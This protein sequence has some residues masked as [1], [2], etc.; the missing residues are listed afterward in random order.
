ME[1]VLFENFN[2]DIIDREIDWIVDGINIELPKDAVSFTYFNQTDPDNVYHREYR[3]GEKLPSR[4]GLQLISIAK[5][6]N[7][8][9]YEDT[10]SNTTEDYE[11]A[12]PIYDNLS[13][14]VENGIPKFNV[15]KNNTVLVKNKELLEITLNHIINNSL[16][17]GRAK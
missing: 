7:I 15:V 9:S 14:Y 16:N 4:F 3:I 13:I 8:S 17:K 5:K 11:E 10:F 2:G 6:N 1:F 12:F